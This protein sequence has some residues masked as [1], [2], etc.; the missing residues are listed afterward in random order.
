MKRSRTS[1]L[2]I[3]NHKEE[4]TYHRHEQRIITSRKDSGR[5]STSCS[6][7][8]LFENDTATSSS[9][10]YRSSSSPLLSNVM[11]CWLRFSLL[12]CLL[13]G[14]S[15]HG[16]LR[17]PRSRN[18]VAYEDRIYNDQTAFDPLPE[19]CPHCLNRGGTLARCGILNP[20]TFDAR[21]YDHPMSAIGY[22]LPA[23]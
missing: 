8:Q 11:S 21:N 4:D 5:T 14:V 6:G 20:D 3:D 1:R 9:C 16:F 19:D 2:Y 10:V 15:G 12:L 22:P 17:S 23:K 18:L 13:A 7:R